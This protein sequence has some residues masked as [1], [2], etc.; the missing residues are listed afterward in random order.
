MIRRWLGVAVLSVAAGCG[1]HDRSATRD[2]ALPA[3][4]AVVDS[5]AVTGEAAVDM[6]RSYLFRPETLTV[7]VGT[8]V[9]WTNH[10]AFTHGVRMAGESVTARPGASVAHVFRQAGDVAYDCPFHPQMMK[11]VIRVV[12][13]G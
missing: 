4:G 13:G 12:A 10:D 9:T 8:R 7:R 11:G 3:P 2:A 6:P 1:G 5:A